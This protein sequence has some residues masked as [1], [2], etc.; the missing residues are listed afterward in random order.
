MGTVALIEAGPSDEGRPEV[1]DFRRY[2]EVAWEGPLS[3]RLAILPPADGNPR[4][5]YPAGRV[6]GGS[7]SHN[8]CIWFRPPASDFAD[9]AA[10]G[11][12]GWGPTETTACLD[13]LEARVR[14]ETVAPDSPAHGDLLRAAREIGFRDVDFAHPFGAGIGLYRLSKIG[15]L[16]QSASVAFLHPLA[17]LPRNLALFTEAEAYCLTFDAEGRATGV[18][19]ARGRFTARRE[20]VLSAGAFGSPR[21]LMLS[22]IGPAEDLRRLGLAVRRDLAGVGAHLLDHPACAINLAARRAPERID[23][24]NYAGVIFA[25]LR[26]RAAWPDIEIQI[27]PELFEQETSPAGYPSAPAGFCAYFTVNRAVSE[28]RVRLA[29]ADPAVPATIEPNFFGDPAGEDLAVMT[30]AVRLSRRL[31]AAPALAAWV[32]PELAPGAACDSDGAIGGFLRRTVTTGYHP[33]G[34]CRMGPRDDPRSVV[35]P[36]LKVQG[37]PGLRVADASIFPSMVSV[38]IAPTCMMVGLR[39]AQILRQEARS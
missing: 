36:D 31:F 10:L 20:V 8:S 13:A 35:G 5:V 4:V 34:T 29:S 21:L 11:A 19:T 18:E 24:W 7:T 9:W 22:G 23:P 1:A 25:S 17:G 6:L 38:N 33:A 30:A 16:R 39:A 26:D 37:V 28:G 32:G 14:I 27:G 15:H 3:Q 2:R 12:T